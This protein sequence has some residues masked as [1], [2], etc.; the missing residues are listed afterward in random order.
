MLKNGSFSNTPWD[1]SAGHSSINGLQDVSA[2]IVAVAAIDK[3]SSEL[4]SRTQ[5]TALAVNMSDY[6]TAMQPGD[7][8]GH[9]QAAVDENGVTPAIPRVALSAIRFYERYFYLP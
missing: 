9:W 1:T 6:T 7:L 5:L 2:I 8:L 3:K 4:I